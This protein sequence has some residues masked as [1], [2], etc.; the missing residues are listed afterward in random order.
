MPMG[1][2]YLT[3]ALMERLSQILLAV[4]PTLARLVTGQLLLLW[5]PLME[6]EVIH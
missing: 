3:E 5:N 1:L 6:T 2:W 4:L